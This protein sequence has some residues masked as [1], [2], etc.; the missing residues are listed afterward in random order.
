MGKRVLLSQWQ[1]RTAQRLNAQRAKSS[2]DDEEVH[3]GRSHKKGT[4]KNHRNSMLCPCYKKRRPYWNDDQPA[5]LDYIRPF[6]GRIL[7]WMAG[8]C[9]GPHWGWTKKLEQ[10]DWCND[11]IAQVRIWNISSMSWL[12]RACILQVNVLHIKLNV[13]NVWLSGTSGSSGHLQ[14]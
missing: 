13:M 2:M 11:F 14:K 4:Q 5:V 12:E 1:A 3:P 10:L 8:V 7:P 6:S 9:L